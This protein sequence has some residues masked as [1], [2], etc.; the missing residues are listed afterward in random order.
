MKYIATIDDKTYEIEINSE[1]EISLDGK[2]LSVD[3]L[4][5]GGPP[6]ISLL[7]EGSSYEA[8]VNPTDVGWE[9]FLLG[10]RYLVVVEDERQ[11]QLREVSIAQAV[12][13]E[14]FHLKAPMP[15][16]IVTIPIEE[17]EKVKRGTNLVV[18]E[19]M[20]MQNELKAP[21]DGEVT[22]IRVKP[23][24]NVDQEQVLV[25]LE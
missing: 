6:I 25:V 18:L 17:G 16:M 12:H 15:G 4:P 23:G 2:S 13:R 9:V 22:A 10:Q 8:H 14:T 21:R 7:L 3:F 11:R 19:S 24:D 5:I 20:K 1:H